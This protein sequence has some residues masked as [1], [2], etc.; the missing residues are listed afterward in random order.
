MAKNKNPETVALSP[1]EASDLK[2]RI[3]DSSLP[4]SDIELMLGLIAFNQW[5]QERLS[6]AKLTIKRLRHLFGFKNESQKKSNQGDS[7]S[8]DSDEIG[9]DTSQVAANQI[10]DP[11]L[12]CDP[13]NKN[14]PPMV[15][16]WNNDKN[17]GRMGADEYT[18]CEV[19]TVEFD[20]KHL[21]HGECPRC[22]ESN[23]SANVYSVEPKVLIFLNSSPLI[24]GERYELK[25][26][27]CLVCQTYFVAPTP[28]AIK[29]RP[30]YSPGCVSTL[31]IHH[32][33]G[34]LPF[35]RIEK[36]QKLS[37]IPMPDAT[38]YDKVDA[39]YQSSVKPVVNVLR[40]QA[41]NGNSL[42]FDDTTGRIL[43]QITQNKKA[44]HP[45]DKAAVH[46]TALLS[47]HKG[48]RIY[49]FDTNKLTAGKQLKQTLETRT[50]EDPF[51]SMSDAIAS[52]FPQLNENLLA[53]WVISLCLAHARRR[54]VELISKGDE[55]IALVL[56][57]ISRVYQHDRT[58]KDQQMDDAQRLAYHQTHSAPLME[59]LRIW[60]N[61]L[62]LFKK[63]EPNSRLGEAITY[64]LKRWHC[65]TEFLRTPGAALDNN[66]C[67]QAIKILIRYRK[68]SLFYRTYYGASI[69]DAM[70]SLIHTAAS[71]DINVFDYLTLLQ[72]HTESVQAAPE[73]WLPWNYKETLTTMDEAVPDVLNSS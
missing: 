27:R 31:C 16:Q 28:E 34:G 49:L 42:F 26:A 23:T 1:K 39:F 56:D 21:K 48:R 6:R 18:G 17:H 66:I 62:I 54:F 63:V 67:E 32:Y 71:A 15:P 46:A 73:Q 40:Q 19:I 20:E 35:K 64:L 2:K 14:K 10:E 44:H 13:K 4:S 47:E 24:C 55:D 59:S 61:N 22:A 7:N 60:L 51:T 37:G 41:A 9:S 72:I 25:Q 3:K 50:S 65:L 52:N 68:N 29:D 38:Q 5:L 8:G 12:P 58:C 45:E 70:M 57:I 11:N 43:D 36:L 30:K 53:K 69:G 33:Y